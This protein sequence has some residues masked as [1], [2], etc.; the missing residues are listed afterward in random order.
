MTLSLPI[1][2]TPWH[3]LYIVNLNA[4][5]ESIAKI[6]DFMILLSC[7]MIALVV[8]LSNV[9]SRIMT[10]RIVSLRDAAVSIS[11]GNLN[12]TLDTD[13]YCDEISDMQRSFCKMVSR[14]SDLLDERFQMAI[15]LKNA[16]IKALQAQI[17]PHFLYNTLDIISWKAIR[18][19]N[20]DIYHLIKNLAKYYK[21]SL[22]QGQDIV[23]LADELDHI[24]YYVNIQNE[25]MNH[26]IQLTI[27]I[28]DGLR[29][30]TLPK[31]TLQPIVENSILHGLMEK[32]PP[33][34]KISIDALFHDNVVEIRI[35]D[36]GVGIGPEKLEGI[37]GEQ[38]SS[39]HHTGYG[40][41]NVRYRLRLTVG[42]D[43][44]IE[45]KPDLGT[46]VTILLPDRKDSDTSSM[47]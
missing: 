25:R 36:D 18:Q 44:K 34:G 33:G 24:K 7:G 12:I 2:K 41:S 19:K 45:S 6:R 30:P 17:N 22:N 9:L 42:G 27:D 4:A 13:D 46:K 43:L 35:V 37:L 15:N 31:L 28:D 21:L 3:L 26:V 39:D 8:L 11:E 47:D 16:E 5:L 1:A 10:K 32:D 20:Y 23:P 14:L 29:N 38:I 40:L